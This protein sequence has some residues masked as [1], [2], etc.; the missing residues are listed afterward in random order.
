MEKNTFTS[1]VYIDAP[2]TE[3]AAFLANGVNLNEC[4]LNSRMH[5]QIDE[6][7]WRGVA[8][9]YQTDLYYH[10]R[11]RNIDSLQIVE[12]HTGAHSSL[13]IDRPEVGVWAPK[14]PVAV[15]QR[16][17]EV[18]PDHDQ[19]SIA[20]VLNQEGFQSAKGLPFNQYTVGYIVRTR[21]WG[22]KAETS[23]AK[24]R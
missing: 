3:V 6:S 7:T 4:T 2:A 19:A 9:G 16:I 13:L 17:Q 15:E 20:S 21:G 14:T 11:R 12:W 10:V 1:S 23:S 8:S 18:L 22:R 24:P 5:E